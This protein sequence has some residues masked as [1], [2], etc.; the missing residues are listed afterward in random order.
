VAAGRVVSH[1]E[2]ESAMHRKWLR[3]AGA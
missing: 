1:E 2:V 3:G